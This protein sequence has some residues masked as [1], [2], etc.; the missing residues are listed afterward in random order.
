MIEHFSV[1]FC[2]VFRR[3]KIAEIP[4]NHSTQGF[5]KVYPEAL[6]A[7]CRGFESLTAHRKINLVQVISSFTPEGIYL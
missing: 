7:G 3:T 6:Q 5:E 2:M 1:H 4:A